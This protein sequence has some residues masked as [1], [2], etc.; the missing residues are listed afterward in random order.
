MST[1]VK[2]YDIAQ[3]VYSTEFRSVHSRIANEAIDLVESIMLTDAFIDAA[4][5]AS[6]HPRYTGAGA[7]F[8]ECALAIGGKQFQMYVDFLFAKIRRISPWLLQEKK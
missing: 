3:D 1:W 8:S 6:G 2:T 4:F 7:I 5:E